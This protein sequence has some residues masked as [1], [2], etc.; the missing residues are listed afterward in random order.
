MRYVF[1]L[2][3]LAALIATV[4]PPVLFFVDRMDLPTMKQIL[5]L[6]TMVWFAVTP[7]W[8]GREKKQPAET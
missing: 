5:L 4:V 8:M 6:A 7:V 2:M 1:Q 3:S